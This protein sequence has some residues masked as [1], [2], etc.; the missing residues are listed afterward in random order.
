[1]Q[2]ELQ[3]QVAIVTGAA[4]GLGSAISARLAIAGATIAAA[5]IDCAGAERAVQGLDA[6]AVEL[7]VTDPASAES[8][9]Q[10]VLERYGR[11]DIL[12]NNAGIPGPMASVV[13]LAPADWRRVIAVNLDGAFHCTRACLPAMLT[14]RSGRIVN[15]SSIAGQDGNPLMAA[16]SASKAGIIAL[17]KSVAKE[18]VSAGVLVNCV[19]PAAIDAGMTDSV[20]AAERELFR[21]RIPI[22][23]LGRPEE[24]GELVAWIASSRCSFSSGATFD[25]SGGRSVH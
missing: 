16:Y 9:A 23:R 6:L 12:V 19:V 22:G 7:D 17:T 5:D 15:I 14:A 2:R 18:V 8:M 24:L 3:D 20:G 10:T 1:M 13:E 21:S 11:I 25:L 4:G